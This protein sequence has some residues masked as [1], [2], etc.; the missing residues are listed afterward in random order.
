MKWTSEGTAAIALFKKK[1]L[2]KYRFVEISSNFCRHSVGLFDT[3]AWSSLVCTLFSAVKFCDRTQLIQDISLNPH[4]TKVLTTLA[5]SCY[6][7]IWQTRRLETLHDGN[8]LELSLLALI[9]SYSQVFQR[10]L[11]HVAMYSPHPVPLSGDYFRSYDKVGSANST[12]DGIRFQSVS[13]E[14]LNN[15]CKRLIPHV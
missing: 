12:T 2:E 1:C 10:Y 13:E 9:V 14:L 3:G 6:F 4:A 7:S 11:T 5:K 8:I 15:N